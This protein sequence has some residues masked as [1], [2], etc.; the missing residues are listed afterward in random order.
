MSHNALFVDAIRAQPK[1]LALAHFALTRDLQRARLAEWMPGETVAV[2]A[3]GA[4]SHSGNAFVAVLAEAGFRAVNLTASD[5]LLAADG[6][7]PADHYVV[8]SESGRSPETIEA[9][10][11]LTVGRRI[12][13]SNF[14]EAQ[15]GEVIDA[16]LGLGGFNDSPVYTIGYTATLLAYALLLDRL[17]IVPAGPEVEQI[18][19]IVE[20]ALNAFDSIAESVSRFV[21]EADAIDVIGRGTSFASAAETALLIRE[22]LRIPSGSYE[23]FQYLHG[24][25]ESAAPGTVLIIFG[26]GRE[27]TVPDAVVDSGVRVILVTAAPESAIPSAGHANLTIVPLDPSLDGFV[28]P[29]V[30]IVFSQLLLAHAM[31]R[32]PFPIE[33]FIYEQHDTKVEEMGVGRE[34]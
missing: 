21:G 16:P 26:D 9:A 25:M 12:G 7:Q 30:E 18:S 24:P 19:A 13:I 15:I 5:V 3:M 2:V 14:P 32:K 8:V 28:R 31:G 10:R 17:A 27:L 20:G 22:G 33:E 34:A 6:F 1:E 29:I 4:S 11:G 23:T